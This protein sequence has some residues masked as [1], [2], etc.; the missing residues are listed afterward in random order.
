[1]HLALVGSETLLGKEVE[2]VLKQR[3]PEARI[4]NYAATGEGS[5]G[6]SDEE[7]E[8][9]YHGPL[10]KDALKQSDFVIFAGT[11]GGATKLYELARPLRKRPRLI[12]CTGLLEEHPE[13]VISD[14]SGRISAGVAGWLTVVPHPAA[15]LLM[16]VL[17]RLVQ[18]GAVRQTIA[19]VFEPASERGKRG[20]TE[21]HQQT[22]ELLAFKPMEKSVFDVQLS[23]N[24]LPGYGEDAPVKLASVEQRIEKHV[25]SLLGQA[26]N[27][28]TKFV[29]I[30]SIRLVQV[31]VFHGYS[32]SLWVE[33]DKNV[34]R[35]R[36]E[37][38]LASAEI[39]VRS[40]DQEF[41]TSVGA[42]GQS[43]LVAGDI[44]VDVNNARAAW[45]WVV[46]DNLHVM[47]DA[48]GDLLAKQSGLKK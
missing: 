35:L 41:P 3:F 19:H 13:A 43:G 39:E 20:V 36:L 14:G 45:V 18:L 26:H 42:T 31:P 10:D 12:D 9:V 23:F 27:V 8:A 30:P 38:A 2:G 37:E 6:E 25:A 7:G 22:L 32:A 46:A 21:L 1:M 33:F 11:P 48:V 28:G 24:L 44:R 29:P 17:N 47:A 40:A 4:S 5:F 15:I 16:T 34:E